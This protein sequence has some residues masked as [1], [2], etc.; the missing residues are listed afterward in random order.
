MNYRCYF[1]RA[2]EFPTVWSIDEGDQSTEINV[3]DIKINSGCTAE[4][5]YDRTVKPNND[6]ATAWFTVPNAVL[7]IR[8]C[9]A[10]F[11]PDSKR[12]LLATVNID[13]S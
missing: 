7:E 6:T 11:F 12:L 2:S 9:V 13:A 5:H 3:T 1:N 4:T 8:D 10:H